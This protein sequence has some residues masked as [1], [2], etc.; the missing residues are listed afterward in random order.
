MI[1]PTL[2]TGRWPDE[3]TLLTGLIAVRLK[4]GAKES[5][6]DRVAIE[7]FT[8]LRGAEG[9]QMIRLAKMLLVQSRDGEITVDAVV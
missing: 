8:D 2:D 6:G 4:I 3:V 5:A 1:E 7:V 9:P